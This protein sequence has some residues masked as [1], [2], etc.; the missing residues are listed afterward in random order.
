MPGHDEG[1]ARDLRPIQGARR[2]CSDRSPPNHPQEIARC[3]L[4]VL[5]V[6]AVAASLLSLSV[7]SET[8]R[9]DSMNAVTSQAL[10]DDAG[11]RPFRVNVPEAKLVDLRNRI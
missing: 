2:E 8:P 7:K 9:S 6:A 1:V 3:R 5:T 11:I 4:S 10:N